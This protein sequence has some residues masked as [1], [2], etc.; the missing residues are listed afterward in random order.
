MTARRKLKTPEMVLLIISE[1]SIREI[2]GLTGEVNR[3]VLL[4]HVSFI[5]TIGDK[6]DIFGFISEDPRLK[7]LLVHLYESTP[8]VA[9]RIVKTINDAFKALLERRKAEKTLGNPFR[10]IDKT[11]QPAPGKLFKCQLHRRDIKPDKVIGAGQFGQ[12]Y[13]ATF[14]NEKV[15]VKTVRLAA[16][17]DDKEDFV[18]E[19]SVM[20]DLKNDGLVQL[21]G[22]AVQQKPWL[23]VIE[24][25][26][27]GDLKDVLQTC[28][29]RNFQVSLW[30][31]VK[32]LTQLA[33]GL[34]YHFIE[35]GARIFSPCTHLLVS[36]FAMIYIVLCSQQLMS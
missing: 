6:K 7:R 22:V 32:I 2:D 13:L 27:Y 1:D 23:C 34:R 31:Q 5:T 12:V 9:L 36:A 10:A 8:T 21:L 17:E 16:G 14:K 26:K 29:E 11:R 33:D 28:K 3:S 30:E 18:H 25:M 20:L 15:A 35:Q 19:A 4:S 24:F